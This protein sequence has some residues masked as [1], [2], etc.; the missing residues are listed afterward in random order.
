LRNLERGNEV[1]QPAVDF[2]CPHW[3]ISFGNPVWR[4]AVMVLV[5][6][7]LTLLAATLAWLTRSRMNEADKNELTMRGAIS[8]SWLGH[9]LSSPFNR[10][11]ARDPAPRQT[12][13]KP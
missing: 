4:G 6:L 12:K 13:V 5:P 1:V 9:S 2:L 3:Q 11:E 7:T 8:R 10:N